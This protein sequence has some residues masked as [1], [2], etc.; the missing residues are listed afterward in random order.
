MSFIIQNNLVIFI[1]TFGDINALDTNSG[2]LVWQAQTVNEDTFESSFLLKSSRLVSDKET[3][4]VSN[5]QNKFFAINLK[6]GLIKWEQSINSHIEAT[7]IENLVFTISQEGYLFVID[8]KT[9]NI[10]RSTNILNFKKNKDI[11]PSGF[12]V[13]KNYIFVSL[14]NG[15]LL[16]VSIADGKTSD[17]IRIDSGKILRPYA[18]NKNMYILKL[19]NV[20]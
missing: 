20:S 19:I 13:A 5:N 14:N 4:Y 6:N 15:K 11:Y 18:V 3:I 1:D 17:I 7:V 16:K 8:K 9:G 10:L 12:I 2:K